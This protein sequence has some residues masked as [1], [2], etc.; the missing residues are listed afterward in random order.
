MIMATVADYIV[1]RDTEVTITPNPQTGAAGEHRLSLTLPD[2]AELSSNSQRAVLM[3]KLRTENGS[4][5][6]EIDVN[7]RRQRN[8]PQAQSVAERTMHKVINKS[9][10]RYGANDFTLPSCERDRGTKLFVSDII[11]WF[12]R[13]AVAFD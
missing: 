7:A 4:I 2:G 6:A 3:F 9:D 8:L 11:L 5:N 13:E 10:L 1:I 12:Q